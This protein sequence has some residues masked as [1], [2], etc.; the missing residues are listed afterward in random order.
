MDLSKDTE[1]EVKFLSEL[2]DHHLS[3]EES[4]EFAR[5]KGKKVMAW[6]GCVRLLSLPGSR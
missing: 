3:W 6:V 2:N 4:R 1:S 5:T